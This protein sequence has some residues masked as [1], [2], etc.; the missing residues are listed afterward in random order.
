MESCLLGITLAELVLPEEEI[1]TYNAPSL[2]EPSEITRKQP[3]SKERN[4]IKK[5]L[6]LG[7]VTTLERSESDNSSPTASCTTN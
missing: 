3:F 5:H 2:L 4:L 1:E 6:V 7:A